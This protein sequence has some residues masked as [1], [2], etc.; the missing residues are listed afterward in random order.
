MVQA[1]TYEREAYDSVQ[2]ETQKLID[3]IKRKDEDDYKEKT[4]QFLELLRKL[5]EAKKGMNKNTG[6][7]RFSILEDF[8]RFQ[9]KDDNGRK[10]KQIDEF[11]VLTEIVKQDRGDIL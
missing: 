5:K 10:N 11:R 3:L 7:N 9:E 1:A 2:V 8:D 6:S 4:V